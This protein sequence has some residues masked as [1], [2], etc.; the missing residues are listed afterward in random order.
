[1]RKS[2][3]QGPLK[4]LISAINILQERSLI[5]WSPTHLLPPQHGHIIV[6]V[7]GEPTAIIWHDAGYGELSISVW[8]K[9]DYN[10]YV[11]RGPMIANFAATLPAASR[12]R[13]PQFVGATAS[14]WLERK[15]GT[16]TQGEPARLFDV[17][18]RKGLEEEL[19]ALPW[20][21]PRGFKISGDYYL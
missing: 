8:W 4:L 1:M 9:F 17:Y 15:N 2:K 13:Y 18:T 19:D 14:V 10:A 7:A 16:F 21:E 20:E 5:S 6:E 3:G 12:K 11:R